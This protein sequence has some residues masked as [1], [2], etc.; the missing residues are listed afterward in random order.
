MLYCRAARPC[1]QYR[2]SSTAGTPRQQYRQQPHMPATCNTPHT[3]QSKQQSKQRKGRKRPTPA[4]A[5]ATKQVQ[6]Q[7]RDRGSGFRNP[8][9]HIQRSEEGSGCR[10]QTLNPPPKGHKQPTQAKS[11]AR[12]STGTPKKPQNPLPS[13]KN[14]NSQAPKSP[15]AVP[16]QNPMCKCSNGEPSLLLWSRLNPDG[17]LN[18]SNNCRWR[19]PLVGPDRL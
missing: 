17:P 11:K 10:V 7:K 15:E 4:H 2:S 18:S 8:V 12:R 16:T 1:Q 13:H 14:R 3:T 5:P 19:K 6:A 9:P